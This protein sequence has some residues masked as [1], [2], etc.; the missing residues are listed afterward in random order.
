MTFKANASDLTK[1]GTRLRKSHPEVSK[2]LRRAVR[3]EGRKIADA[4]KGKAS[5]S[6]RIPDTIRVAAQGVN[7]AVVRAGG[8][9]APHAAAYEHSGRAGTFRHPVFADGSKTRDQWTWVNQQ[10]RPFLHPAA[11]ERLPETVRALGDAVQAAVDN[12]IEG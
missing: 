7:T 11:L 3:A 4:A 9:D 6:T 2:Q 10:A 5:W 8:K 12:V 1:L